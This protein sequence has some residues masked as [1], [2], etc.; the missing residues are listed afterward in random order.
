[1]KSLVIAEP[2]QKTNSVQ[3]RRARTATGGARLWAVAS[4]GGVLAFGGGCSSE[5]GSGPGPLAS[6]LGGT[7]T[8]GPGTGTS[9]GGPGNPTPSATDPVTGLPVATGPTDSGTNAPVGT[10]VPGPEGTAT[11]APTTTVPQEMV[12]PNELIARPVTTLVPTPRIARLSRSQWTNTVRELLKLEDISEIDEGVTGDALIGFDSEADALFVTEQLRRQLEDA[13]EQL[14]D[15]VTADPDALARLEPANAPADEA[16]R[17]SAFVAEFGARAFRRPLTAEEQSVHLALFDEGPVLYPGVDTFEAG[18]SLVIQA[19]LQSPHF[20]YRTELGM[21]EAGATT[22]PLNDYE[23]ASKIALA[24]TNNMPDDELFAA[25]AAGELRDRAN[26]QAHARRLQEDKG[27]AG[28]A[29]FNYQAFRLGTYDGIIRDPEVFPNFTPEMPASM[30][31]EVIH[32][33]D[34]IFKQGLGVRDFY[35]SPVGFV[36]SDLAPLYGLEGEFTSDTFT[37][38]DL[39]PT[40]RSGF[41]T[42]AGFLSSY[43]SDTQPDIIHRGVF[44]ATRLLCIVLPPPDPAAG[45]LID[46]QPDM[47]NRERVEATTGKGTCG[48]G[49][50][51]ALL[52]PLGYGFENYDALGQYRTLDRGLPVNASD[53]Y[54][55]DGEVK[56]FTNG[57]ELSHLLAETKQTHNCYARNLASYLHG[58]PMTREDTAIIDYYARQSRAGMLSLKDLELDIVTSDAFLARLP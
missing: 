39:D 51:S 58:R 12:D 43:I 27:S 49:C 6:E 24:L 40:L 55:L 16:G 33:F 34:W 56:T 21:A 35:T 14:A 26:V 7:P 20:L 3:A 5:V 38:V 19:M 13:A 31:Q 23:V 25:A 8:G 9:A 46:I 37:Q 15:Q 54:T 4:I 36:N 17:A 28:L 11:V 42:Q 32:F 52:N 10:L 57:V 48:E 2:K 29:N 41:L 18:A 47:T 1:M 45:K 30:R 44:I 53:S 50:H 22:V